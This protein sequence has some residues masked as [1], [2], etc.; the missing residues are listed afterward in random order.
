MPAGCDFVCENK[1][2]KNYN[3]GIVITGPW[4]L[5]EI[6]K[7]INAPNVKKNKE[8]QEGLI[9]LKNDGQKYACIIYP[10]FNKIDTIGYRVSMWCSKCLCIYKYDA[11]VL[12][13]NEETE[14]T[15]A[16]ANIPTHC[17]KCNTELKSFFNLIDEKDNGIACPACSVF[18]TKN[19]WFS[20]EVTS[21]IL[22]DRRMGVQ[23][24]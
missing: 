16:N 17:N 13:P 11:M 5:G 22:D 9:K 6:D 21:E 7:V 3:T 23:K 20:Q 24:K 4:P 12:D 1:E 18:T 14:K 10:N 8:F 19:S 2:C 15:I